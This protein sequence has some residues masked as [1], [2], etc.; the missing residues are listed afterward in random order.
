MNDCSFKVSAPGK[1]IL[2]GEHAVVYGKRAIA[3]A[4]NLRTTI[5]CKPCENAANGGHLEFFLRSPL[6]HK[7]EFSFRVGLAEVRQLCSHTTCTRETA[8][9]V[10]P[11]IIDLK[12]IASISDV[13]HQAA[14][15]QV[16]DKLSG[17]S[18]SN[19]YDMM[20][21]A[22][23]AF[24][25]LCAVLFDPTTLQPFALHITTSVPLAAG[26]GSSASFSVALCTVLL[27]VSGLLT[28]EASK[29]AASATASSSRHHLSASERELIRK[30]SFVIET[31][32]HERPSGIDNTIVTFGGLGSF[33]IGEF[34]PL[35][36]PC[37]SQ[38]A[39]RSSGPFPFRVL[40]VNTRVQRSTRDLV[41]RVRQASERRPRL[42]EAIFS[43]IGTLVDEFID[44]YTHCVSVDS[45]TS[46]GDSSRTKLTFEWL[47]EQVRLSQSFL[48]V[49]DVSHPQ[50]DLVRSILLSDLGV[51][52]KLTG[53]GGGGVVVAFLPHVAVAGDGRDD[54]EKR[55]D[56]ALKRLEAA[57]FEVLITDVGAPGVEFE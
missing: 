54:F 22:L 45:D 41:L 40:L 23:I 47:N 21:R 53:A 14:A 29:D 35:L 56:A 7:G 30:W 24:L 4:V 38:P 50:I 8:Y 5:E 1:V 48:E 6:M 37:A 15:C 32:F 33:E 2:F 26:L 46:E 16:G 51:R 31:M 9:A 13:L 55:V 49:L 25:F 57:G 28:S 17:A 18:N 39:R 19:D 3:A 36:H 34:R 11:S 44:A 42:Y 52:A 43:A 27:R 12:L 20:K 10:G